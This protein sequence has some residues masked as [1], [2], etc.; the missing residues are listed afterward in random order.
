MYIRM[1]CVC[2]L[3]IYVQ[4]VGKNDRVL[5]FSDGS[6]LSMMAVD[7]GAGKVCCLLLLLLC[8]SVCVCFIVEF[9]LFLYI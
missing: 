9:F 8:I 2:I 6:L 7:I 5:V 3:Y 4:V 1:Y